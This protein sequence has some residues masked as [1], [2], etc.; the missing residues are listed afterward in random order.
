MTYRC[1]NC[2]VENKITFTILA[3]CEISRSFPKLRDNF[4]KY[5]HFRGIIYKIAIISYK[6][7]KFLSCKYFRDNVVPFF[8]SVSNIPLSGDF[9]CLLFFKYPLPKKKSS[10]SYFRNNPRNYL[11]DIF[12]IFFRY[13]AKIYIFENKRK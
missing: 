2:R 8:P 1:Q 13:N 4:F 7:R 5:V 11:C 10:F 6:C 9:F 12:F 3:Q